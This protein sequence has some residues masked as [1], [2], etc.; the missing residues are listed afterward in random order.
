MLKAVFGRKFLSPV[1]TGPENTTT[2]RYGGTNVGDGGEGYRGVGRGKCRTRSPPLY[3]V[4][5]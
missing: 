4:S 1:E 2:V 5:V 3:D